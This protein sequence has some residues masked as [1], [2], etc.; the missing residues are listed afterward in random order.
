MTTTRTFSA[1]SW[2]HAVSG[3]AD[4]DA[5]QI[6]NGQLLLVARDVQVARDDLRFR[7]EAARQLREE[8][9]DFLTETIAGKQS[10]RKNSLS[11]GDLRTH[12]YKNNLP[13]KHHYSISL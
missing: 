2:I 6:L 12:A 13:S 11:H 1:L 3:L 8:V 4:R 7:E 9:V 5:A 10:H